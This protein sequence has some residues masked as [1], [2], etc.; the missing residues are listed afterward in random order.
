MS[1]PLTSIFKKAPSFWEKK[2]LLAYLLWPIAYL[3]GFISN[4]RR[5]AFELNI[6]KSGK[7]SVPL[8][9]VGNIRVGGTGKTPVVIELARQLVALGFHPGI[10]SRGYTQSSKNIRK[11]SADNSRAVS[12][13]SDPSI[14]GDEPVLMASALHDLNVPVWIGRDR[15]AC[16]KALIAAHPECNVIISDDG[17][18]HYKLARHPA[19]EG[20]SDIEIVVRDGREDGNGFVLPAGPLRE[21]PDRPRD[22]TL[23]NQATV[24]T[25]PYLASAP[26]FKVS[27]AVDYPYQL[28]HPEQRKPLSDFN[29]KLVLASAGLGNPEKFFEILRTAG[30]TLKTLPL[31]DHFSF[32]VNPFDKEAFSGIDSILI[33]EKDAVKCQSLKDERIW[34]VPLRAQLPNEMLVWVK[35]VLDRSSSNSTSS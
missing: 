3:F 19:R 27:A 22:L 15:L 1:S 31:P 33:T 9:I 23:Q 35:S 12:P 6:L 10:I 14:D 20:G 26:V 11:D 25:P 2:G 8:I 7:L 28:N 4:L 17:L 32:E 16:G 18:Q 34:V 13:F 21:S 5:T 24:L 29:G 30:L